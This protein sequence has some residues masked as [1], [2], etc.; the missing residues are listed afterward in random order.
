MHNTSVPTL[1]RSSRV[2]VAVPMLVTSLEPGAQF[3]QVC[4]TLEVSAHGCAMRSPMKLE[5][6]VPLH[7]HSQ[8]GREATAQVVYCQPIGADR[9]SWRVA[10]QFDQ[11]EN[12]WELKTYPKDWARLTPAAEMPA[13]RP[14]GSIQTIPPNP[15]TASAKIVLDRIKRQ[16]S[17]EHLKAM[18]AELVQPL[19]AE[20][21]DLKDKLARGSQKNKFEVS[22]SQIPPELEQQLELRLRNHLGPQVLQQAKQHSEHVLEAAKVAIA[23]KTTET[24]ADFVQRVTQE[25]RAVEQ[26]AQA[27]ST[28]VDQT[29]R[30]HL[31][32][33][34]GELHQQVVDAGNRLKRLSEDLLRVMEHTL[35][36][37]HDSRLREFEQVQEAV[38]SESSRLQEQIGGLDQRMAELDE[39]A[40]RLESG[41]DKRLSQMASDTVRSARG[42]ME[43]ALEAALHEL[44][45]RNA[46]EL[47]NQLD[48]AST[49]LKL[50]QRG[51]ESSVAESLKVQVADSLKSFE[52]SME[53]LAQLSVERW[54]VALAGGLNSLVSTLGEQFRLQAASGNAGKHSRAK[55]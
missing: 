49:N 1:R 26:R 33:G 52:L 6:G 29:M 9:N 36:E 16:L 5:A 11:P 38:A 13:K 20:V 2:P 41:L 24:H 19:Q 43:S 7:F 28:D 51:I 18:L 40:K 8:E 54:R 47:G 21:M 4:E 10:A 46:Q 25:L 30:E 42:Q 27:V 17:D 15:A 14:S 53:E 55:S 22:L 45:T 50:I 31:N 23:Q 32:R 39:C 3:S 12:F 44:S 37:E 35:G 48:E 34:M